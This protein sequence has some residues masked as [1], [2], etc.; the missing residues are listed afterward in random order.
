MAGIGLR[1]P[2]QVGA[3]RSDVRQVQAQVAAAKAELA[4]TRDEV[5]AEVERAR[6]AVEESLAVARLYRER[7]LPLARQRLDAAQSAYMVGKS[8]FQAVLEA[9]QAL[10]EVELGLDR[11][12]AELEANRA[13]LDYAVGVM[14]DCDRRGGA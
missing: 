2:L 8:D 4:A 1:L 13:S 7:L 14:A 9:E 5:L 10:R 11:T 3:I 12:L 6:R